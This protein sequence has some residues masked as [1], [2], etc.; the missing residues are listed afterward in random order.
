M[1]IFVPK[2]GRDFAK[3]NPKG[4][5][6]RRAALSRQTAAIARNALHSTSR[7]LLYLFCVRLVACIIFGDFDG[8]QL[9]HP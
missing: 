7:P 1:L 9:H 8:L 6:Q 5:A 2:T 3:Q 4:P